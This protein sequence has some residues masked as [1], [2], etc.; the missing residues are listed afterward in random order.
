MQKLIRSHHFSS[1]NKHKRLN[2]STHGWEVI[3]PN[4]L[5]FYFN[6]S[7]AGC[8][9]KDDGFLWIFYA[10]VII[11]TSV[12]ISINVSIKCEARSGFWRRLI[13][14]RS[15]LST[16]NSCFRNCCG[17]CVVY[18]VEIGRSRCQEENYVTYII[19]VKLWNFDIYIVLLVSKQSSLS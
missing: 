9:K 17:S 18:R 13:H 12:S 3:L 16:G 4:E 10:P 1:V 2:L 8:L 19:L 6:C 7:G 14:S 5:T 11:I 15:Y